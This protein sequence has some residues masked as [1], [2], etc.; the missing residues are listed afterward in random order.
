MIERCNTECLMPDALAVA[1]RVTAKHK[2]YYVESYVQ[3]IYAYGTL[4]Y[5]NEKRSLVLFIATR[6][7]TRVNKIME[8]L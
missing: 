8:R 5:E 6:T 1:T 4:L 3:L 7:S 2:Q